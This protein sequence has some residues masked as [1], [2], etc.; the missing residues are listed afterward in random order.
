MDYQVQSA[1]NIFISINDVL[2]FE[3]VAAL[4]LQRKENLSY[5]FFVSIDEDLR[6]KRFFLEYKRRGFILTETENLFKQRLTDEYQNI[7]QA[8]VSTQV[9]MNP[10]NY[11]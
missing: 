5:S 7:L 2:I 4:S 6:T 3:G 1:E 8:A 9:V 10:F 11:H